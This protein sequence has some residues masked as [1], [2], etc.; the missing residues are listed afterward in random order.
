[1]TADIH[2]G[3]ADRS[4][5]G[6]DS[7]P[8]Y[9]AGKTRLGSIGKQ[10]GPHFR[11]DTVGAEHEIVASFRPVAQ[12][13]LYAAITADQRRERG[14]QMHTSA[15]GPGCFAQNARKNRPKDP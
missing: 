11:V 10:R 3:T 12:R 14:A 4:R 8:A 5:A 2:G 15:A 6:H 1:P 9:L 7:A 13:N